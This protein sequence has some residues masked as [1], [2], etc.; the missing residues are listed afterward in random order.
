VVLQD[1][2]L[3]NA[4]LQMSHNLGDGGDVELANQKYS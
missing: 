3:Q 1:A 2:M 4:V